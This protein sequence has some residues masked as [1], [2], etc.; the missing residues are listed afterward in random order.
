MY[1]LV[2]IGA[3][4]AGLG[5]SIYASR[6]KLNHV[7]IGAEVGGQV[8]EAWEIENYAGIESIS[9][10]NLMDKFVKQTKELGGVII[11]NNVIKIDKI[12]NIF[13]VMTEDG[14]KYETKSI[15]LALGMK[16]RKMNIP[17]ED[18]FLGK[19]IS[20]CATCDA[21]FFR[22]KDVAVIGGGDAAATAALHLSEFANSVH[23]LYKEGTKTFEPAWDVQMAKIGKISAS[24]FTCITSIIGDE[25]VEGLEYELNGEK[26]ELS[27]QGVFI[28]IGSV[29]GVVVAQDLGVNIDEQGYIIVDQAQATNVENVYAAG[30]AT[31]GSNKFRQIITAVAEGSV[32]AGSAYRKMKLTVTKK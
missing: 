24:T 11:E 4:P 1:D 30:D 8:T 26:K 25:K 27:L 15:I 6:Y 10:K 21:M 19:G 9:G 20:Y 7:V 16:A 13:S 29:P 23:L 18:K 3:G 5:A 2:I 31:T 12:D 14:K 22:G 28:E 32:A 17:G